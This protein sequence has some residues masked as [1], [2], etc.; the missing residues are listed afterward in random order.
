MIAVTGAT[1]Q[2]GQLVIQH[3]LNRTEASNIVALVRDPDKAQ[4]IR[5]Q[6]V[7]VRQADYDRP[8]TLTT[9][10]KGVSKLL[11]VSSSA[12]GQ[13]VAQHQAVIDAAKAEGVTLLA[14][15]SILRADT[16]PL[17]LAQ[18][19]KKTEAAL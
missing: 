17:I 2:L 9:A 7:E 5:D 13:R 8:E 1:G 11:L 18:E 4:S 14:Y 3:L 12:V 10:L 6:G 15:T 19:H 16:S